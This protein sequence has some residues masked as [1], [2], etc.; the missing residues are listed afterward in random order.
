MS[1]RG[2]GGALGISK[3][4]TSLGA[5]GFFTTADVL[6]NVL[7]GKWPSVPEIT[8]VDYLVIAGG[9][10]GGLT[11]ASGY[12]SGGGAGGYRT[13]VG[14]SGGGALSENSINV[15]FVETYLVTVGAGGTA[16]TYPSTNPS[17]GSDSVFGSITSL[18]GGAGGP[19]N[20]AG[21]SGGS[22]GGGGRTSGLGGDGTSG[23]GYS[24]GAGTSSTAG[25]GGGGA[26]GPGQDAATLY[27]AGLGGVGVSSTI[28]GTSV[29]RGGGGSGSTQPSPG[30]G[31]GA[32]NG[33]PSKDGSN[34]TGGGGAGSPG[35]GSISG[36]GG[37]GVVILK[38]PSDKTLSNPG[39]GLT[40]ST[41][42][43]GSF[44]VTTF[45]AGTGNIQ[46]S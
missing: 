7:E 1:R 3:T 38:Y 2:R 13:S 34:N 28:T 39:G 35:A 19:I 33:D 17:N 21:N 14:T 6:N 44:K 22:G 46:W 32:S 45:T 18:G 11:P 31:G 30:G 40:Y 16:A 4:L 43:D 24:G 10:G 26:G 8:L 25:G 37:S 42:D 29:I 20:T 27:I 5:S 41:A 15:S 12:P 23:Q 9:G 36:T